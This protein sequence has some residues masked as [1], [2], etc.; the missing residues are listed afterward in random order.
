MSAAGPLFKPFRALGYITDDVPFA[1]QWRGKE[2]YVT[3]SVGRTWQIYNTAKLTLV[4][5]G[6]QLRHTVTA[7]AVK[8]DLTFAATGAVIEEC[9]RMHKVGEYAGH[10]GTVLQML[11]IGDM[12]LSLGADRRL[13]IW[14]IGQHEEP[15][16]CIEFDDGFAPSALCHPDTYLNKVLVGGEDGRLQLWNFVTGARLHTFKGWGSAV[17]CLVSSPALDV[18]GMG[19]ADGR[20]VLHNVRYD[21]TVVAFDNAAGAGTA[22]ERFGPGSSG[23]L[24]ISG[25]SSAGGAGAGRACTC[26][27]FRTGPGLPLMAAGGGAGVVSV[28]DLEERRLH[29]LLRD[30]HDGPLLS[31]H[32]F[33]GEPLLMSS[34]ADNSIK[35]WVFDGADAT[36]R[37]LRFRSGHSAPP[38]VVAHYA[39]GL[40]LLS[41]GADRAFRVFSSIQDQQSRELSQKHAARRAKKARVREEEVKLPRIL[42]LAAS[43]ARERDWSN[44]ITAHEGDLTAYTWRLQHFT[45][46]EAKLKPPPTELA[47]RPAAPVTA[48]AVSPCG[49]YGLVGS[50]A[51]RIDRYNMQSGLHRGVFSRRVPRGQ[52]GATNGGLLPAHDGAV[53]GLAVDSCNRLLVSLGASDG[54]L[55]TWDFKKQSLVA[56]VAVGCA[57]SHLALHPASG[58]AAVAGADLVIRMYDVEASRLVRRFPGHRDRIT[59]LCISSDCRW[60]LSSSLD[61]CVR[62]WDV[63]AGLCLQALAL[64]SPVT[65][66]SLSPAK[67]LLATTHAHKRG[68]FLWSNQLMF[69]EAGAVALNADR[70]VPVALP[71]VA[72]GTRTDEDRQQKQGPRVTAM[73]IDGEEDGDEALSS[74][75]FFAACGHSDSSSEEEEEEGGSGDERRQRR[76]HLP[77]TAAA[78]A[79]AAHEDRAPPVYERRGPAGGGAPL[80]LSPELVTLSLLPRAQWETL[81]HLDAIKAR[82]KPIQP[83]K[84]PEAAPF[85]L[86]TVPGLEGNPVFDTAAAAAAT[87][88][89]AQQNAT[90]AGAAAANGQATGGKP[91][92]KL[93]GWGADGSGSEGEGE[94]DTS[95][96][97]SGDDGAGATATAAAVRTAPGSRV[98][99]TQPAHAPHLSTF[100]RLLRSCG[101]AGDY[102]S[103]MG[104]VR[105][106]SPAALDRELRGLVLLE[107]ASPREVEDV[108]LLLECLEGELVGGRNYEFCQALLQH[109]LTVHGD[110]LISHD[111]LAGA[112]ERMQRRLRASWRKLDDLLQSTRCIVDFLSNTQGV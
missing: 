53:A 48:V 105:G 1:V 91:K 39:E 27:S 108:R 20:A 9:K 5:V 10:R 32:F 106:L 19:L 71:S 7:L 26:I 57:A 64:G 112:A 85:F 96:S 65:C 81:L 61:G 14:R 25:S 50:A 102:A 42:A 75:D 43:E 41:A 69:G 18:V 101:D 33:P 46:G 23:A 92:Q 4:M 11:V 99:R 104:H 31:L 87:G 36:A 12:L 111:Q 72:T 30:A 34:A 86:P 90:A 58:L 21:E 17:R 44:V 24:G 47:G 93:A 22:D 83:P 84:K 51:G 67:D 56:E 79:A 107:G 13:L 73:A 40:R 110:A 74:D 29:G 89:E 103:F 35:Q 6:P 45:I 88:T 98:V 82:S 52:A 55:R 15:E 49:N 95:G 94:R 70:P 62:V 80:P 63:P 68:V 100:L 97:D 109:V 76:Q 59:S 60:L 77:K 28:W 66:L 38:T 37:L 78:V 8:G 3:V 16:V 54:A 2:A